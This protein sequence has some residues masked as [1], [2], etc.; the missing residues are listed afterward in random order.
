[1]FQ[2]IAQNYDEY[3]I[4]DVEQENDNLSKFKIK[5][6]LGIQNIVLY[7]ISFFVSMVSFDSNIAPFGLA[8]FAAACSNGIPA[9]ILFLVNGIAML[10]KFGVN[11]FLTY[12]LT[13]LIFVV[14]IL[15]IKPKVTEENRNEKKKLGFSLFISTTLVQA[16]KMFFD[17]FLVYDLLV[18]IMTGIIT[19]IFYKI[20][21]NSLTVINSFNE[22]K[23][24][25]IEEVIGASLLLS[26]AVSAFSNIEVFG[27]SITNIFSIMF[28]LILGWKNGMLVG[29]TAGVTIGVVLGII[30][31]TEPMLL[32]AY[33]LSGMCAGILN[34]LGKIG[35]IIGFIAGN[36]VL[37]YT[38]NG[39]VAPVILI[40]EILVASLGLLLLPKKISIDIE[41]LLGKNKL[42]P[43]TAGNRLEGQVETIEKLNSMSETISEIAQS[44]NEAAATVEEDLEE[45]KQ[46]NVFKAE[47][48]NNM[49]QYQNNILYDD[50]VD[51]EECILDKIY[52]ELELNEE[53][54]KER[55]LKIFEESNSYI[56][57]LDDKEYADKLNKDI[58]NVVNVINDTYKI[59]KLNLIWSK[60]MQD[61]KKNISH[62]LNGVSQAISSLA[63]NIIE[64]PKETKNQPRFIIQV[65]ASRTTKSESEVSGD[66]SCQSRL[67]DGKYMIAI[68]DG[69]GSGK[70]AKKS[71][72]TAIKMLE[73]LLTSGFDKD[74]SLGLINSTISLNCKEDMFSTIDI[75]II[76]LIEGNIEFIKNG[77]APSYIKHRRN[78]EVIKSISLPA[79]ILNNVDLVVYD[80]DIND[81]DIIVMCSDGIIESN[82]E[83]NNKELW[84]R[85]V[86][87]NIETDNVQKIADIII[88]EAIDNGYGIAKD[89]MTVFVIKVNEIK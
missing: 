3:E 60:K 17:I 41:E 14:Q 30:N 27:L 32:A 10:F 23:A 25:S 76:D 70:E 67:H 89:D 81:G 50:I 62:Q 48:I 63:E 28:V 86:L 5:K 20:F 85:D 68:S 39:N 47:L 9:G 11:T 53:L 73:R 40:K 84:L 49:E 51:L 72:S 19:Y 38:L 65:G 80:K 82:T 13:S 24:F 64:E 78:V 29:T 1:M 2:N 55:L 26:I 31:S 46:K 7:V 16:S 54:K 36:A 79:G 61:N 12:I 33:A 83:Y 6:L 74:I 21:S 42:L 56:I 4:Q 71:S 87:E 35:V 88:A 37:A 18:S 66:S 52:E 77:A 44:Y 45:I 22:K 15:I 57:G 69:M 8:I 58:T 43:V 75:G 34:K 59:N